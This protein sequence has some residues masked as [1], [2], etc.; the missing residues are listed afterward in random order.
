VQPWVFAAQDLQRRG[1]RNAV[2]RPNVVSHPTHLEPEILIQ[3]N[4]QHQ[5]RLSIP[6]FRI[7]PVSVQSTCLTKPTCHGDV[8]VNSSPLTTTPFLTGLSAQLDLLFKTKSMPTF[9][10]TCTLNKSTS[11]AHGRIRD[12]GRPVVSCTTS[13]IAYVVFSSSSGGPALRL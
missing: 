2:S 6:P 12:L 4:F 10:G 13:G 7:H 9:D 1:P 3:I 8:S 11:S 5:V